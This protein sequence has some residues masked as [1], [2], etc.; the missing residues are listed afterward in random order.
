MKEWFKAM[1]IRTLKTFAESAVALLCVGYAGILDVNWI[2]VLSASA[3]AALI[4]ALTCIAGLPEV[5]DGTTVF[6]LGA[7]SSDAEVSEDK[8]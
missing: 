5:N 2:A 3:L 1:G 7:S 4:A 8:E 6:K